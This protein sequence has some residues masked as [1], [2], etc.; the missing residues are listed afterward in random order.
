MKYDNTNIRRQDRL[1][2]EESACRLLRN[3][4]YGV[5]SMIDQNYDAYGIPI[6]YVY[7][8]IADCIYY[9]CAKDGRKLQSILL[10]P[11]V[12]F[13][14]I[15]NTNVI[16]SKFTTEYESIIISGHLNRV[17]NDEELRHALRLFLSKYSPDEVEVGMMYA[18]KSLN[19]TDI[20]KLTPT[21]MSG[22]SK[23][24]Y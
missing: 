22:K 19:R 3:G 1:L 10:H 15:G 12:S 7:D 2:D 21:Q 9:H 13:C 24:I 17:S 6:N 20:L 14:V 16:S 5:L 11:Q 4:E 23:K 18:D 8:E